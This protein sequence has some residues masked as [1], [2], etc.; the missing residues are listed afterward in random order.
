MSVAKVIEVKAS[1][2]Q[3]FE[4]AVHQ[5]IARATDSL[6]DVTGAWIQDQQVK[7]V[8]G[9]ISEYRVALKVTFVLKPAA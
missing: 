9:K 5:G 6:D 3:S 4:D 8:N 2:N 7:V 1:S